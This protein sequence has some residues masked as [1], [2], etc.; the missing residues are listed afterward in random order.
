MR[1]SAVRRGPDPPSPRTPGTG[2]AGRRY[3]TRRGAYLLYI[4]GRLKYRISSGL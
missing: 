1:T 4:L 2:R 3:I